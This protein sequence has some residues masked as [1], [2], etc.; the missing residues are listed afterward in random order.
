[1][2]SM[3]TG[4]LEIK[5]F[6]TYKNTIRRISIL[7]QNKDSD[8]QFNDSVNFTDSDECNQKE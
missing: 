7:T 5:Y 2:A 8:N 6:D 3:I 1:M 4:Q